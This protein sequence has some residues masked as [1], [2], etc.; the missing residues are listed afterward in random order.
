[1]NKIFAVAAAI[2]AIGSAGAASAVSIV[3]G[4]FETVGIT[5]P[6]TPANNSYREVLAPNAVALPGWMVGLSGPLGSAGVDVVRSFWQASDGSYSLDLAARDAGS[7]SQTLT[8]LTTGFSYTIT[9]DISSNP[10]AGAAPRSLLLSVGALT[11]TTF[12]FL[13]PTRTRAD[14]NWSTQ[15]YTFIATG[16][17]ALLTFA[18]VPLAASARASLKSAGIALDNVAIA[19]TFAT[20]VPEPESWM[21]MI[22]GFGMIGFAA[23]RRKTAVA[24]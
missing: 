21:M 3:N 14:M 2:A 5:I 24:A 11:P 9:F 10:G 13:D 18:G 16:N 8:G 7:I 1:M 20:Q 23:R 17:T 12:T 4:S 6:A 19:Q 22:A 15:S